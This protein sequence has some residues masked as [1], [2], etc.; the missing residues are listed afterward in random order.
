MKIDLRELK[1]LITKDKDWRSRCRNID[2]FHQH[3]MN[4]KKIWSLRKT[5]KALSQLPSTVSEDLKIARYLVHD[6]TL[7]RFKFRKDV[8]LL[9]RKMEK[10]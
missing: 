5:A 1:E 8:L 3:L 10:E 6:P 4:H 2:I 9:L 7:E